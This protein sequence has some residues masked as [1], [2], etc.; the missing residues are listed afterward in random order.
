MHKG[1]IASNWH[2][3]KFRPALASRDVPPFSFMSLRPEAPSGSW[4]KLAAS[5]CFLSICQGVTKGF[6]TDNPQMEVG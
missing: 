4:P 5:G 1:T 6:H 2:W 3:T